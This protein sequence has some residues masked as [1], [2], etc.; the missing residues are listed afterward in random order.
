MADLI[1]PGDMVNNFKIIKTIGRGG[2]GRV[3]EAQ[4][5]NLRRRVAIKFLS[6]DLASDPEMVRRFQTEGMALAKIV[7]QHTVTI[8]SVGEHKGVPYI[9]MEYIEGV[10]LHDHIKQNFPLELDQAVDFWLQMLD[11]VKQLHDKKIIH[12][13]LKPKNMIVDTSG[14]LKIVDFGIA[15]I[16]QDEEHELTQLGTVLG[17][18]NYIAPEIARGEPATT[19]TDIRS[20]GIIFYEMLVGRVP[21]KSKNRIEVLKKIDSVDIKFPP[22]LEGKVPVRLKQIVLRMCERSLNLRYRS[23][24][25]IKLDILKWRKNP[26]AVEEQQIHLD[27]RIDPVTHTPSFTSTPQQSSRRGRA[28][29]ISDSSRAMPP[30]QYDFNDLEVTKMANRTSMNI[31]KVDLNKGR[32]VAALGALVML[33]AGFLLFTNDDTSSEPSVPGNQVVENAI[34]E[35]TPTQL[36]NPADRQII[37]SSYSNLSRPAKVDFQWISATTEGEHHLEVA[38]DPNFKNIVYMNVT[39]NKSTDDVPLK[40]GSYF[41]RVITYEDPLSKGLYSESKT[42]D[43]LAKK[44]LSN[45]RVPANSTDSK[46]NTK[47]KEI[48]TNNSFTDPRSVIAPTQKVSQLQRISPPILTSG[49]T[50]SIVGADTRI[51]WNRVSKAD[52]YTVEVADNQKFQGKNTYKLNTRNNVLEWTPKKA[53]RYYY[54]VKAVNRDGPDSIFSS[55]KSLNVDSVQP[56]MNVR[57]R[58]DVKVSNPNELKSPQSIPVSW[59]N[60]PAADSYSIVVSRDSSFK[61]VITKTR[62]RES[63]AQLR[64]PASTPIFVKVAALNKRGEVVG[65][66]SDPEKTFINPNLDIKSPSLIQPKNAVRIHPTA[67]NTVFEWAS[68]A[69]SDSF[70]VQFARDRKFKSVISTYSTLVPKYI[71]KNTWQVGKYYWRV[72]AKHQKKFRSEWSSPGIFFIK[73]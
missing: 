41:W 24:D 50:K 20:L 31:Q 19:Q 49:I 67:N 10:D 8:Y 47:R 36:L 68:P 6:V 65:E 27:S 16:M 3:Y 18:L 14:V 55:I 1:K 33:V 25:D 11:G 12:R 39:K 34:V 63:K 22:R 40:P 52:Y 69:H 2:M 72:R 64:L 21:F 37:E 54:R 60:L 43:I 42:F 17:S 66:Y 29:N 28:I 7:H 30:T 26:N 58:Y 51:S 32:V 53:G 61:K 4:D 9:A 59:S 57:N 38:T 73:P 23:V 5:E 13:D 45:T 35:P 56:R 70:E 46:T 71:M 62:T 15:K 48:Q 44:V